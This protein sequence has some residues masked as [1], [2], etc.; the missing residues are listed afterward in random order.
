MGLWLG[1]GLGLGSGLGLEVAVAPDLVHHR[2]AVGVDGLESLRA[3]EEATPRLQEGGALAQH[4]QLALGGAGAD[5]ARLEPAA[6]TVGLLRQMV[7]A[8]VALEGVGAADV[9]LAVGRA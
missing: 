2:A 5:V 7:L 4:A 6:L 9:Q 1:L 3:H 8:L